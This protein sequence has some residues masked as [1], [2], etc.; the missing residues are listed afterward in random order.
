MRIAAWGNSLAVR[1]PKSVV[2]AL[3]LRRGTLVNIRTLDNGALLITPVTLVSTMT[4]ALEPAQS[5]PPR[6]VW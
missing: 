3:Q 4:V 6:T 5:S 1:I 2:Q